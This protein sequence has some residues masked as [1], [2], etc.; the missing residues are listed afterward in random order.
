MFLRRISEVDVRHALENGDIIQ[1][2]PEDQPYP[3]RP[4]LGWRGS[5]PI[6]LV[7]ADNIDEREIVVITGY[8]PDPAQWETDI[9]R[10]RV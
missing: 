7:V 3:S 4:V 10:K 6:Q 9:R 1:E 8:Q 5:Q 2:Y